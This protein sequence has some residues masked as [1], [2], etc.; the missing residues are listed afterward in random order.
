[1]I[2]TIKLYQANS[3]INLFLKDFKSVASA[4]SFLI[5]SMSLPCVQKKNVCSNVIEQVLSLA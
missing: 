1:M 2:I 5:C 4:V 3:L